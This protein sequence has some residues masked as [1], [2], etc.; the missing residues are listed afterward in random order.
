ME[1]IGGLSL[2]YLRHTETNPVR[3]A[4]HLARSGT[5]KTFVGLVRARQGVLGVRKV[6]AAYQE[7]VVIYNKGLKSGRL[8]PVT[9]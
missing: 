8:E 6:E 3:F 9:R 5:P 2:F 7:L 4:E 1:S